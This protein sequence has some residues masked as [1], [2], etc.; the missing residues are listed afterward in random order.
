MTAE[1]GVVVLSHVTSQGV[2]VVHRMTPLTPWVLSFCLWL[3]LS[4]RHIHVSAHRERKGRAY[5][6]TS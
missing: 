6:L 4:P 3:K 1:A 2:G 5:G